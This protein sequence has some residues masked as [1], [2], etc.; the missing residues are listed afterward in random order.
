[1]NHLEAVSCN[2]V[3]DS[4]EKAVLGILI[5]FPETLSRADEL[6]EADFCLENARFVLRA[7]Q[8]LR[9]ENAAIDFITV[10]ERAGAY[11]PAAADFAIECMQGTPCG[12]NVDEYVNIVREL[13]RRREL[14]DLANRLRAQ[15]CDRAKNV[16]GVADGTRESLDGLEKDAHAAMPIDAALSNTFVFLSRLS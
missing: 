5:R 12:A 11:G 13:G 16:A 2:L 1:M 4:A 6:R 10:S 14:V 9:A 3:N 7:V 15:A 8:E